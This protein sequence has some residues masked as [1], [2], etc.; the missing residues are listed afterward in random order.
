[1]RARNLL[2]AANERSRYHLAKV[3]GRPVINLLHVGKTGGTAVKAAL[4]KAVPANDALLRLHKHRVR[5]SDI[6]QGE[7]VVFFLREPISRYVSGFNSRQR[8]GRPRYYSPWSPAERIAFSRFRSADELAVSLSSWD[9][10]VRSAAE[11]AMRSIQHVGASF[12]YW[13]VSDDFFRSRSDDVI[14]IGFQETLNLDFDRLKHLVGLQSELTLP[15]DEVV[16]HR[17]PSE[18]DTKLS[19]Q[20]RTNLSRWYARDEC[21]YRLCK[22]MAATKSSAIGAAEIT[23]MGWRQKTSVS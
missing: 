2:N 15:N 12:Y 18:Q 20:A 4:E 3:R 8:E 14:F 5:L 16:A 10:H 9:P 13:F 23:N 11:D 22:E 1:M 17:S 21:F 6:P 7:N 19:A